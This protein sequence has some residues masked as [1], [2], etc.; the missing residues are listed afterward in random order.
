MLDRGLRELVILRLAQVLESE[1]E[2]THHLVA[3]RAAGVPEA[4]I[5]ALARWRTEPEVYSDRERAALL[6]AEGVADGDVEE[7]AAAAL[8]A[9]FG[10]DEVV[11]VTVTAAFYAMVGRVLDALAVPLDSV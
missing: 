8:A 1:Y 2:W 5:A 3:A 6:Y 4:K 9:Y 10:P 7:P 11:E